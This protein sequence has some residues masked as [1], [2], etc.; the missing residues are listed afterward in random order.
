MG[1]GANFHPKMVDRLQQ[2]AAY[3]DI[4]WQADIMPARTGTDA[5]AIQ[6]SRSGVPTALLSRCGICTRRWRRWI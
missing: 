1:I 2:V 5:W 6:V 4:P 3:H